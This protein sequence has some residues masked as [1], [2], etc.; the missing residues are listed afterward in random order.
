M[1]WDIKCGVECGMWEFGENSYKRLPPLVRL[2]VKI[3]I[4]Y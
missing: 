4:V 1:G 2:L 3:Q